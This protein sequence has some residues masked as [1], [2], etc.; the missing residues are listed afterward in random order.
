MGEMT[1]KEMQRL[2]GLAR[3]AKLTDKQRADSARKAANARWA[4]D[5]KT[6]EKSIRTMN[7]ALDRIEATGRVRKAT[8]RRRGR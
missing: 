6:I 2:G 4:K 7:E 1:A 8:N 5:K 3:A